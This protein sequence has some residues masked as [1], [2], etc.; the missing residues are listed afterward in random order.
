MLVKHKKTV[1][2]LEL[3]IPS[4]HNKSQIQTLNRIITYKISK[5]FKLLK[6]IKLILILTIIKIL[7]K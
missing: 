1:H 2:T 7:I 3:L 5:T 4:D 6:L